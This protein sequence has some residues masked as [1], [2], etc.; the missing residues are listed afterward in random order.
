MSLPLKTH[1]DRCGLPQWLAP[2]LAVGARRLECPRCGHR[3]SAQRLALIRRRA[4]ERR[5][6]ELQLAS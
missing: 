1:C 6:P 4:K 3:A 5:E 2:R